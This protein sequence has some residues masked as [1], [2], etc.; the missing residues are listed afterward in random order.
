MNK[1]KYSRY[2]YTT[3]CAGNTSSVSLHSIMVE[4]F[5]LLP[6]DPDG[7]PVLFPPK[8]TSSLSRKSL[9]ESHCTLLGALERGWASVSAREPA[10]NRERAPSSRHGITNENEVKRKCSEDQHMSRNTCKY[11]RGVHWCDTAE[12][13]NTDQT[14]L[15]F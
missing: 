2:P 11:H 14:L 5:G 6:N 1:L 12:L 13:G 10:Q 4:G 3:I 7:R 15:G 9:M 8:Q